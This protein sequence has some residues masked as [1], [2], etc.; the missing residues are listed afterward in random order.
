MFP[1][2]TFSLLWYTLLLELGSAYIR[3]SGLGPYRLGLVF[4][5]LVICHTAGLARGNT[6]HQ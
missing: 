2:L 6:V 4:V 3:T 5:G 1:F